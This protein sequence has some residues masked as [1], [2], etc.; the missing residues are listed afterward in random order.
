MD[1][2]KAKSKDCRWIATFLTVVFSSL[3]FNGLAFAAVPDLKKAETLIR[4]GKAAE[5]YNFLEPFEAEHAGDPVFDYM[6]A[7]AA[8]N[9]GQPSKASFIYERILAVQPNYIGVRADMGR[10]YF[11]MQNYARAKIEF[12][13]VL[14]FQNVPADLKTAAQQY[15]SAIEQRQQGKKTVAVGYMELA[16]GRDSNI[17]S[18]TGRNPVDVNGF[19]FFLDAQNLRTSARY[20]QLGVGGEVNHQLDDNFGFYGGG[21]LRGRANNE[22]SSANYGTIDGRAGLSYSTGA[23]LYRGGFTAGRYVLDN[24]ATRDNYGVTADWR[25]AVNNSNQLL[26]S[27]AYSENRY[28]Q[29]GSEVNDFNLSLLSV[30]WTMAFGTAGAINAT[31]S[32]GDE[33]AVN[34][35]DDGDRKFYGAR[36]TLQAT[37]TEKVGAFFVLST[38][39]SN[40]DTLNPSF[41]LLRGDTLTDATL[42]LSWSFA[43]RWTLRPLVS[44]IKNKSNIG[45]NDF[46]RTD[47]SITLRRDFY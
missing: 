17:N 16:Y 28:V 23:N 25:H 32:V 39:K 9:S 4:E 21:D 43:D 13:T 18:A 31:L 47:G 19:P 15:L 34:G 14:T 24:N 27:G 45:L 46:K 41:L 10:A 8:L 22:H 42:G 2:I 3:L 5:A 44:L 37:V 1:Y 12:E 29:S 40:Y 35:R 33:H 11:A 26:V 30:G 38:Q 6:L 36:V 7:T 20:W